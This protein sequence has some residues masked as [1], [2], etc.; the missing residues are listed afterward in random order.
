MAGVNEVR[1]I[2]NLGRDPELRYTQGGTAVATLSI[3]T[4]RAY[5]NKDGERKEETEWHRVVVWGKQA[6]HCN[7]YLA[8]G[9]QV[10]VAGRL[11][12]RSYEHEG[13]KK[14]STEIVAES[15]Q[16]LGGKPAGASAG[17]GGEASS[18]PGAGPGTSAG[19]MPEDDIPF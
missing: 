13:I 8:S 18:P 6:E 9:R 11:Q 19:N 3:A 5:S 17:H 16:F 2:G 10:F 7:N 4:T 1:L 15:V 14:F 12:T